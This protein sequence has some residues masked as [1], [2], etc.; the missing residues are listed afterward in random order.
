M[1]HNSACKKYPRHPS[2]SSPQPSFSHPLRLDLFGG[3]KGG[4]VLGSCTAHV[5]AQV[6]NASSS[7]SPS[8]GKGRTFSSLYGVDVRINSCGTQA[9][10]SKEGEGAI[11]PGWQGMRIKVNEEKPER[12]KTG[13]RRRNTELRSVRDCCACS[14]CCSKETATHLVPPI[15]VELLL[16]APTLHLSLPARRLASGPAM[17]EGRRL[18][19]GRRG[20]LGELYRERKISLLH[21]LDKERAGR[22][23]AHRRNVDLRGGDVV[24]L[25]SGV[26]G[27]GRRL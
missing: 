26:G 23:V 22:K 13:D 9:M 1:V 24:E 21:Q 17:V 16:T 11:W 27:V 5:E 3:V 2:F 20:G 6:V 14:S 12:R 19:R 8:G 10:R 15:L 4:L 25:A 18:F 7:R